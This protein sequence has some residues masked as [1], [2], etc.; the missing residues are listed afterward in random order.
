MTLMLHVQLVSMADHNT[1]IILLFTKQG[2]QMFS[3]SLHG[4]NKSG[5]QQTGM[6]LDSGLLV[7]GDVVMLAMFNT[8]FEMIKHG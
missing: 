4:L 8:M 3:L 2:R 7:R 5:K 1:I 6:T